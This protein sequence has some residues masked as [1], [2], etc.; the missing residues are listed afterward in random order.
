MASP[1]FCPTAFLWPDDA[2]LLSQASLMFE[3]TVLFLMQ[4]EA[5][6]LTKRPIDDYYGRFFL[7]VDS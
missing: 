4:G 2:F 7:K 6:G 5:T 3:G 1:L